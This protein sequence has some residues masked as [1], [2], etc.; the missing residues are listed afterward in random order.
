MGVVAI[1]F[2]ANFD[3]RNLDTVR[4]VHLAMT[5]TIGLLLWCFC[6]R[7]G[8]SST[9]ASRWMNIGVTTLQPV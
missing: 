5:V 4:Y 8:V 6:L 9:A 3:F 1:W 2:F 7:L